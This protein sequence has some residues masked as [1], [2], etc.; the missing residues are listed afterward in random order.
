MVS[1]MASDMIEFQWTRCVDGYELRAPEP[2]SAKSKKFIKRRGLVS[3]D[4]YPGS[5]WIREASDRFEPTRPLSVPLFKVFADWKPRTAEGMRRFCDAYGALDFPGGGLGSGS[6]GPGS[7]SLKQAD[8]MLHVQRTLQRA[9]MLLESGDPA[10]LSKRLASGHAG[11]CAPRLA[12]REDGSLTLTLVPDTLLSAMWLQLALH[13]A[14]DA[15]LLSCER[16]A[17]P[18]AVGTGTGRRTTA[19]YCSNAC[20]VAAFKARKEA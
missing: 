13:A 5:L 9:L 12:R 19:K 6:L 18:F 8:W 1:R 16:C 4:P 3:I 15:E 20:K 7:G 10:E 17:M 11:L 2:L 14:S